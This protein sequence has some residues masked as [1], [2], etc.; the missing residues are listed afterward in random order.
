[1][2]AE[3][4]EALGKKRDLTVI[5]KTVY[6]VCADHKA[7]QYNKKYYDPACEIMAQRTNIRN[8]KPLRDRQGKILDQEFIKLFEQIE[9]DTIGGATSEEKGKWGNKVEK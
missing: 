1:M 2:I 6:A 7:A 8:W 4:R 5:W 9:R 3:N